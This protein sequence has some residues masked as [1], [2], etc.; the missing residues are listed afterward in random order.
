MD[1]PADNPGVDAPSLPITL[2]CGFLGAGKTSVL[3]HVI[4][5][6]QGGSLAF[7]V[8]DSSDINLDERGLRGLCAA[9]E[10]EDHLVVGVQD[11]TGHTRW[12]DALPGIVRDAADAGRFERLYIEVGGRI[13]MQSVMKTLPAAEPALRNLDLGSRVD[14]VVTALNAV[15]VWHELVLPALEGHTK[16][17]NAIPKMQAS[18][19]RGASLVVLQHGSKL[20]TGEVQKIEDFV[21]LINPNC[22]FTDADRDGLPVELLTS[23]APEEAIPP[24]MHRAGQRRPTGETNILPPAVAR[25]F[26]YQARRPFHPERFMKAFGERWPRSVLRAKGFFWLATR[27]RFVGGLSQ[28]GPIFSCSMAGEWW[29][30][31]PEERRPLTGHA[32]AELRRNWE[33]PFGDRRQEL[34]IYGQAGFQEEVGDLLDHALLS[35][36]EMA[37]GPD[38]WEEF[39]DPLPIWSQ[40][41]EELP[42]AG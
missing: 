22:L 32:A 19:A 6:H 36:E 27:M 42:Q 31:V 30:S 26:L 39:L 29:A 7:V 23:P 10:R 21:R 3:Q 38:A 25:A 14:N 33:E 20:E 5:E 11:D 28:A 1:A 40:E 41:E 2:V 16:M 17:H 12:Q 35:D 37:L 18:L 24:A 13:D 9:L 34:V 15:Q 4:C 8:M